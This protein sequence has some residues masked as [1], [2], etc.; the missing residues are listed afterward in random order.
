M[1]SALAVIFGLGVIVFFHEAGHFIVA[2][3]VGLDAPRFSIGFPPHILKKKIRGTEYC[4]GAIP[5]GGYVKVNLGTFGDPVT[6]VSWFKR[7]LVGVS[8]PFANLILTALI[9]ILVFGVVG[10]DISVFPTVVGNADN[11]LG[12]AVGDTVLA[13]NGKEVADYDQLLVA[14][15]SSSEGRLLVGTAAGRIET[16][17]ALSP[18]DMPFEPLVPA[19]IGEALVGMPA[20]EAG[21]RPGDS[22]VTM[23]ASPVRIWGDFQ[24]QVM[25]SGGSI[26]VEFYREGV[27]DTALVTPQE[28]DGR[29]LIG[30]TVSIPSVRYILPPG[31]A[32]TE[33]VKSAAKSAADVF[34]TM[35]RMFSRPRELIESSGGPVYVAETLNQQARTGLASY[36]WTI[37]SI[38]LAIMIFNLLPIP[39]LDGGQ[40]LMLVIEG[41]RGKP[42]SRK[43][44]QIMQQAGVLLILTVF[45]LIMFKDI[46]RVITRVR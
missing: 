6:D 46:S 45:V 12:L 44:T 2:K 8:G 11:A 26:E 3:L 30:V 18:T 34:V 42:M 28:Y 39:I 43:G 4:I 21:I 20:Y 32:F 13:V 24:R 35:L 31:R 27:L 29:K 33:G 15:G 40:V 16:E 9:L 19:V 14:L 1:L 22:I 5:L 10:L 25:L 41:L 38:S 37:A 7:A 17:F 36:L 23:N